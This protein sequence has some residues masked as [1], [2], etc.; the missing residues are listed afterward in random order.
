MRTALKNNHINGN[1]QRKL[2]QDDNSDDELLY[3]FTT[4]K[5]ELNFLKEEEEMASDG[6]NKGGIF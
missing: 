3:D 1:F 5:Y 2:C 6:S 4:A